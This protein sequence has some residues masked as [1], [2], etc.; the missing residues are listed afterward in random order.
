[1]EAIEKYLKNVGH[2]NLLEIKKN[3]KQGLWKKFNALLLIHPDLVQTKWMKNL[4][5][6][7]VNA[8]CIAGGKFL[9]PLLE[10]EHKRAKALKFIG[11]IALKYMFFSIYSKTKFLNIFLK[12]ILF[13][14]SSMA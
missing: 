1:M 12:I 5:W 14:I 2:F 6:K 3:S 9:E 7:I 8:S 10:D 4:V 13:S 11:P